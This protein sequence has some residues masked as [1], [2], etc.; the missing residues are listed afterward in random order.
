M[1]CFA[2]PTSRSPLRSSLV[3]A[4]KLEDCHIAS[5]FC[6]AELG[7]QLGVHVLFPCLFWAS[8]PSSLSFYLLVTAKYS[9]FNS[10]AIGLLYYVLL[11]LFLGVPMFYG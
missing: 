5:T 2:K 7:H 6:V 10:N 4:L 8:C 3:L 11:S 9:T 1:I